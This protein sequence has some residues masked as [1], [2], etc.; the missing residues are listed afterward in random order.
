MSESG[1]NLSLLLLLLAYFLGIASGVPIALEPALTNATKVQVSLYYET[2]CPSCRKFV[3]GTLFSAASKLGDIMNLSLFP[4]GNAKLLPDGSIRCQHG[5]DECTL[6]RLETCLLNFVPAKEAMPALK[7]IE[8]S[9][10]PPTKMAGR[11]IIHH[12]AEGARVWNETHAC[13]NGPMGDELELLVA[14]ATMALQPPHNYTPW[15]VIN[16]KPVG[17]DYPSVMAL[18]CEEFDGAKPAACGSAA[19]LPRATRYD[20][21]VPGQADVEEQAPKP[22]NRT[23]LYKKCT[24][25]KALG[26]VC[27]T[28]YQ[29]AN[30]TLGVVVEVPAHGLEFDLPLGR[31]EECLTDVDL[32]V[33]LEELPQLE[34]YKELIKGLIAARGF[35][36]G[37]VFSECVRV[38]NV[39]RGER[40]ISGCLALDSRTM[41]WKAKCLHKGTTEY[42]CFHRNVT[43]GVPASR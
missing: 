6:N 35:I 38:Y 41:C 28:L 34:P 11:C 33:L 14:K 31:E 15:L 42:G 13:T 29:G 17:D 4:W 8:S 2:L 30:E 43:R 19:R 26:R 40:D 1:R 7:C 5:P 37:E 22:Q 36:P 27:L 32:L 16:N 39:T 9:I 21:S 18:I 3:S 23:V 10:L 24:T 25:V 20:V 12:V